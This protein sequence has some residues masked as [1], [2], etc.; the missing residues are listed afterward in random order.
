MTGLASLYVADKA[1]E[2]HAKEWRE[3]H[4]WFGCLMVV[5]P[6]LVVGA[7][8]AENNEAPFGSVHK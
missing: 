8:M 4:H 2:L 3:G 1:F 6:V 7:Y 5:L